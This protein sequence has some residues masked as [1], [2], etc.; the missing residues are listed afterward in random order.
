M[1]PNSSHIAELLIRIFAAVLF[2]FQGY[3]KLFRIKMPAVIA[4]F[5]ADTDRF[6]VPRPLVK[7]IAYYTSL[8]EFF[9]GLFLLAGFFTTYALYA[10]GLDLIIVSIAFS[11]MNPM[12]DMKFV[13]PRF[14]LVITL[15]FIPEHYRFFSLD[16][17]ISTR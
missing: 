8:V 15:L 7:L 13:F 16:H 6:H 3:D 14:I 17:F 4:A 2:I 5:V 10:L 9:A 11:Y 12:W 1:E